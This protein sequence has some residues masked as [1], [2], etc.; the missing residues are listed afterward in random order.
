MVQFKIPV[1][2]FF[3]DYDRHKLGAISRAQFR[4]GLNLAFGSSYVRETYTAEEM[5]LI[6][7]TYAREMLDGEYFV[8]W[9]QFCKD[10]NAAI[11]TPNLETTPNRVP[12]PVVPSLGHDRI[13]LSLAEEERVAAVLQSMRE[14]FRIRAVYVKGVFHDFAKSNNSPMMVDRI[15]RQQFVQGLSRLGICLL[16]TSPSPR[17]S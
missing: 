7:K 2:D 14:R 16:Y 6:E 1:I 9:K 8:D 10:I 17:D 15:T 4:R 12:A 11:Y 3:V 5:A 13:E